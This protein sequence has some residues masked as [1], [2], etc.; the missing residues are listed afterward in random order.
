MK[1]LLGAASAA[2]LL[3]TLLFSIGPAYDA[4]ATDGTTTCNR[5]NVAI[6]LDASNS[7]QYTDPDGLRYEAIDQFVGLLAEQGNLVGGVVFST[8]VESRFEPK[9]MQ[10]AQDKTAVM[11]FFRS[12]GTYTYTDI[13]DALSAATKMLQTSGNPDL[14]SVIVFLSD[15]NSEMPTEKELDVSL[16]AKADAVQSA[17]DQK[18]QIYSICLNANHRAD[19]TEMAQLAA[20]TGGVFQEV[21]DAKDLKDV[22]N[23]FYDLIYGTSTVEL[24]D[25]IFPADGILRTT[26]DVP[27]FGVEEVNIV[28]NGS[29]TVLS[30]LRPDGTACPNGGMTTTQSNTFTLIKITDLT[31]G[32]WTLVTKGVPGDQIQINMVYN[33]DLEVQVTADPAADSLSAGDTLN[34]TAKLSAG[35]VQADNVSQYQG[36]SGEL[37]IL[38][39]YGKQTDTVSMKVSGSGFTAQYRFDNPGT[40][41]YQVAVT[42]NHLEKTSETQGP[43]SVAEQGKKNTNTA[44]VPVNDPIRKT[45]WLL[46]F[47][48]GSMVLN[49]TGLAKDD[50]D[51]TLTYNIESSSFLEGTDYTLQNN[52]LTQNHFSLKKGSY[53]IRATDSGG[54]HCEIEVNVVTHSVGMMTLIG[55]GVLALAALLGLYLALRKPFRGTILAQSCVNG[56][57]HGTPRTPSRGRCKLSLFEIDDVGLD[58]P[59][60][61]FQAT[62]Q[63]FIWLVTNRPVLWNGQ[64]TRRVRCQNGAET[65]VTASEGDS[66]MLCIRFTSRI[67]RGGGTRGPKAP[68]APKTPKA[69]K[70]PK[71]VGGWTPGH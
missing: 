21:D 69:P 71:N 17:R 26:F 20:A 39:A 8:K 66:R 2:V 59:K 36:Y 9:E 14:P 58:A 5:Y 62:G 47:R 28:I 68:R 12:T 16:T 3:L 35:G 51:D 53:T 56:V 6:V 57:Y 13:G 40:Y 65:I 1:K 50:Q 23:S 29:A 22:F 55:L 52:V 43:L 48:G 24:K 37:Q 18:I 44:P 10:S 49:L 4:R 34:V 19:T 64:K 27:S 54:L 67:Q 33:T 60:C 7:M 61:Y 42:G 41:Y 30:L 11:D 70:A 63:N 38:D 45:V 46:P 15:G 32:E 25:G 31:A